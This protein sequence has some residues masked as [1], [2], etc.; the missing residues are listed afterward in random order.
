MPN[1]VAWLVGASSGI[2]Q[3][4]AFKLAD[5][6]WQVAI[7]ARSEHALEEMHV[8]HSNL[9]VFPV[10]VT[11]PALLKTSF[12]TIEAELGSVDLCF[13]NAGDYTPMPL[14]QFDTQ[15]FRRLIEVN[16]MGV[17]N[18]LDTV[19]PAMT[20]RQE[21]Q[22]LL[23]ASL[24]SYRGL[25]KSAPYSASKA[26]VLNLAESLHLELKQQ[27]VLLRVINPGF[28]RSPLTAKNDF[29]M[30][31]LMEPEDAAEVIMRK[32]P[33]KQFEIRFPLPFA[34]IMK[35]LSLLPYTLFF[36]LTRKAAQ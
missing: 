23:T 26:A 1:K 4:L 2:G 34:L 3:A 17:V 31:F 27:G 7:S 22:I 13:F 25:P 16:Y 36:W 21:G 28:V 32:L 10:D 6:D 29:N 9:H 24:A 12:Q 14:A 5:A 33:S 15:L 35:T 8:Q 19:I 18:A 30:P 11:D 20:K